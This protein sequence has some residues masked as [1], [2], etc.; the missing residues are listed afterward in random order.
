[1][2]SSNFVILPTSNRNRWRTII[3]TTGRVTSAAELVNAIMAYHPDKKDWTFDTLLGYLNRFISPTESQS[4]FRDIYPL[5]HAAL[6]ASI[7]EL[8]S[9]KLLNVAS[10]VKLLELTEKQSVIVVI[11]C[12]FCTWPG[13]STR[14]RTLGNC[15]FQNIFAKQSTLAETFNMYQ[16]LNS[17]IHYL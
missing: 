8:Q 11:N 17:F 4:F 6:T 13:R 15:N 12:F 14:S 1:M 5:M 7:N 9:W 10:G 3:Q 16:K 2:S